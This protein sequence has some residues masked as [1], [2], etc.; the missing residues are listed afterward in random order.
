MKSGLPPA[1]RA[2]RS[3]SSV[4]DVVADQRVCVLRGE[5]LEAQRPRPA[6]TPLH[7][8]RPSHAQEQERRAR[9]EQRR[10]L[11]QIEERLVAPLDVVEDD[12]Q[13]RLLLE[14]LPER[15]GDLVPARPDLRLA[16]QRANRRRRDRIRR[17]HRE[18]LHHLDHRPVG[19]PLAV[20]QAAATHDASL[21]RG[22]RLRHEPRLAHSCVADHRHQLA[23]RLRLRALP[24]LHDLRELRARARRTASVAALRRVQHRDEPVGRHRLRLPLQR[25]WLDRLRD[26]GLVHERV[27]RLADQHLARLGRLLEPRRHVHRVAGREPLRRARHHLAGVHADPAADAELRQ[28]V[29][30]LHRRPAR[31]QRVV[32]VRRPARRTPP[33]PRRR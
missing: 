12:D 26:R 22:E 2:I 14:Q 16:Q 21:D 28:R 5:R 29:A 31:P 8:L 30:H 1:A 7:Q 17:Q 4:R 20:G 9:R 27:R 24:R 18:L 11:D 3:R 15:P 10:R 19:D 6:G 23:P 13:R 25:Q 32:L 33:S